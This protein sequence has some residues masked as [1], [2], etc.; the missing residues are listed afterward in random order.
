MAFECK[1]AVKLL[2]LMLL[3]LTASHG[4]SEDLVLEW[5]DNSNNETGFIVERSIDGERFERIAVLG[6]NST[7]FSDADAMD[8]DQFWYRVQAFN[9]F[10]RSGFVHSGL[11]V[12][13]GVAAPP[14]KPSA[15]RVRSRMLTCDLTIEQFTGLRVWKSRDL[16]SNE[17]KYVNEPIWYNLADGVRLELPL[18][19]ENRVF[20]KFEQSRS[21]F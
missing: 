13:G 3:I 17:W 9:D 15:Q 16:D 6:V 7:R 12:V 1:Y 20:Y 2:G 18:G 21:A 19:E 4:Y 5:T 8:G 10:G 11:V 14:W